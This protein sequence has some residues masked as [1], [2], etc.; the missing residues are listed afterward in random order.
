MMR[1][2]DPTSPLAQ[3]T[4]LSV[5]FVDLVGF[6]I[7]A[8]L[9]PFYVMRTGVPTA[10]VTLIIASYSLFQ[11]IAMPF[12]GHISD[13]FGRRPVLALSMAG[14]AASWVLLAFSDSWQMLLIARCL[15]GI[16]S[17]NLPT[18]YA[19]VTDT[20]PAQDRTKAL[21]R[22]SGSFALGFVV[23]PMIGGLLAG[24]GDVMNAN[25]ERPALAAAFLSLLSFLGILLFL[26][27]SH[28]VKADG[29]RGPA[30]PSFLKGLAQVGQRPVIVA[31]VI[32][33]LMVIT[34]VAIRE[35]IMSI[36]A[37]ERLA[38]NA[39]EIGIVLAVSGMTIGIVQFFLMGPLAKRFGEVRLAY[40]AIFL[41][42]AG[43]IGLIL[44]ANL[45]HVAAATIA[46]GAATA[47]FQTNMQSLLSQQ[48]GASERGMIMG[49]YQSSSSIARFIG[50][51]SSGS[52]YAIGGA[53]APFAI[54]AAVM[55]PALLV[56]IWI[57]RH[58]AQIS[59]N[60]AAE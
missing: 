20:T 17:A 60:A 24:S 47:F 8:P 33:C 50:Q 12:F 38:L 54:G 10:S 22:I 58:L 57:G 55:I 11:F 6:G 13:R 19:Y 7:L 23:G 37:Y 4:L 46:S 53:N 15:G 32:L 45:W 21:G 41:F 49:V 30:R 1:R 36:W 27:E 18:A 29:S 9:I 56:M 2:Q 5:V 39:R 35:A 48:A 34:C 52:I 28:P 51:A 3:W 31:I 25:L 43:W 44:S 59:A 26:P 16:T 14:H 42:A 40:A